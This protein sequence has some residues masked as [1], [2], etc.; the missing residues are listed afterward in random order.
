ML[1]RQR[2]FQRPAR[3]RR[4][5]NGIPAS[6]LPLPNPPRNGQQHILMLMFPGQ[7]LQMF[8]HAHVQQISFGK[9]PGPLPGQ[10]RFIRRGRRPAAPTDAAAD[11]QKNRPTQQ[12]MQNRIAFH[13]SFHF[14][15]MQS[16]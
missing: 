10:N 9:F 11:S 7:R 1:V 3:S 6:G 8:V 12:P 15:S 13:A 5:L 16:P 4:S 14:S 2:H